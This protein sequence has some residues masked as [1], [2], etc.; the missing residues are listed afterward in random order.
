MANRLSERHQKKVDPVPVTL[1]KLLAKAPF[2]LQRALGPNVTQPVGD[3]VHVGIHTDAGFVECNRQHQIGGFSTYPRQGQ[4]LFQGIRDLPMETSEQL[5]ADFV[6]PLGLCPV[7]TDRED[8]PPDLGKGQTEKFRRGLSLCQEPPGREPG[9]IIL[10]S[11]G[12]VT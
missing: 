3:P 1:G 10:G 6:D 5:S 12:K 7:E 8:Q 2:R 11:Q 9:D 4:K